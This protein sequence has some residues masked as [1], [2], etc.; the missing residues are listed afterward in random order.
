MS[1]ISDKYNQSELRNILGQPTTEEQSCPDGVGRFRHFQGGSIYWT[2]VTGAH[3]VWG[4]I[5]NKWRS[6]GG[7][8]SPLGYPMTDEMTTPDGQGRY[9]HFQG[10]SIY[11]T[12]DTGPHIVW[13]AIRDLWASLG[14]ERS[15]LGYPV[16]DELAPPGKLR[17]QKFQKGA[18]TF[19]P[20][21]GAKELPRADTYYLIGI[22][23][24]HIGCTRSKFTDTDHIKI[25]VAIDGVPLQDLP[26]MHV[27]DVRD[28]DHLV[29]LYYPPITLPKKDSVVT[30]NYNISNIGNGDYTAIE[31]GMSEA[32]KA[33]L[34]AWLGPVG[35]GIA[36]IAD[37]IYHIFNA[38]C[39]GPVAVDQISATGYL[40]DS[41]T[42]G[43]NIHSETRYYTGQSQY[44]CGA[45]YKYWV[46]WSII[47]L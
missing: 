12:P 33:G 10:G 19:T 22:N 13:G 25:V 28:G 29:D 39:D 5:L 35:G 45:D 21:D 4:G 40:L 31:N 15:Y 24:F 16:T 42:A 7:E 18:I 1:A 2:P 32:A 46:T 23:S 38:S 47:R 6:M 27:G 8:R 26:V 34:T 17:C 44:F 20:Q 3:I 11:W 36:E 30:F 9:N 37:K 14:W 43:S 41:W